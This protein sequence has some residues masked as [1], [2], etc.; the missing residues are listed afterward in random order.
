MLYHPSKVHLCVLC[1]A[2]A[3]ISPSAHAVVAVSNLAAPDN[4][5]GVDARNSQYL[6]MSFTV[7]TGFSQWSLNSITVRAAAGPAQPAASLIVQL[8]SDVAGS[9][10][11]S[12]LQSFTGSNP[13]LT[14]SN[15]VY[16]PATTIVLTEG[17][18]Y[19]VTLTSNTAEGSDTY[20]WILTDPI[21]TTETGLPGWSIGNDLASSSD[22]GDTWFTFSA[23]PAKFSIDATGIAVPE[24]TAAFLLGISLV[25]L[26]TRRKRN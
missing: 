22:Q 4:G 21:S 10:S 12:V 9:P 15:L 14:P 16:T 6:G 1:A 8:R 24:P 2:L 11:S 19:W 17:S 18:T 5:S 23:D 20:S 25:G 7:G 3:V 26:G 13:G